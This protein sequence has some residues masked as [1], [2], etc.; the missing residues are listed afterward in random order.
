MTQTLLGFDFGSC[1]IGVAVG[2]TI[3]HTARGIATVANNAKGPDWPALDNLVR[4][5]QPE[6]LIVGLPLNMERQATAMSRRADTFARQLERRYKLPVTMEDE[7]LS[8]RAAESLIRE[9]TVAKKTSPTKQLKQRDQVAA[10][11]ILESHLKRQKD[12]GPHL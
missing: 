9:N 10:A 1:R 5:W 6:K 4:D 12:T 2:Q 7:R 11:L 3:S 8:S